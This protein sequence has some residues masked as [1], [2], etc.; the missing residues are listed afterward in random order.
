MRS[1]YT[2]MTEYLEKSTS[3]LKNEKMRDILLG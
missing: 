1:Q 2:A 3:V